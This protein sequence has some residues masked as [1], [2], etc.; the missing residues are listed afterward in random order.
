MK[1]TLKRF[2]ILIVIISS[3]FSCDP[4]YHF[5]INGE[6]KYKVTCDNGIIEITANKLLQSYRI[7]V[8]SIDRDF[9]VNVDSLKFNFI[10]TS[11]NQS[12]NIYYM[13]KGEK[14][15]GQNILEENQQLN[16]SLEF[17][18]YSYPTDILILPC[19]FILCNDRPLITDTIR[20]N[21]K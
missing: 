9:E 3:L 21:L 11:L 15:R 12:V 17:P 7:C 16:I 5:G 6:K 18:K 19:G 20:I 8:N 10:P 1:S 2:S 13:Y 14:I 4:I